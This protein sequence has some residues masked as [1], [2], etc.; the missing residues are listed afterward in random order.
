MKSSSTSLDA[1]DIRI[2]KVLQENSRLT[3]KELAAAVH[4]SPTPTFERVKRLEREG[5]IT[6]YM[7]VLDAEKIDCG[8]LA[9]CYLKMKQQSYENAI[10]IM[11]AVKSIRLFPVCS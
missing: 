10:R 7:A 11:T 1:I 6:K 5:Y 4:L 2:L 8:F 3:V 9:F